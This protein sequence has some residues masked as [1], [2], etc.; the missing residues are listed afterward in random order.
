MFIYE[1][2]TKNVVSVKPDYSVSKAFQIL[3]ESRHSQLPVVD[4]N[5]KLTGLLTEKLLAEVNPSKAT[6]LSVYEINYLLSKTKVCDIMRTG[7]FKVNQNAL[8]EDA[9][10]IM[11]ENHIGSLPVVDDDNN[12]VGI[13]TRVDI[14]K[15]FIDI[16]GV[17]VPGT[18]LS[19]KASDKVGELAEISQIIA[20]HNVN[21]K[22]IS[23]F[24]TS[25]GSEIIIK[26][27]SFETDDIIN[28]LKQK[29]YEI[30]SV[31][32]QR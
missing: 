17:K 32:V 12:L 31:S 18:R 8:I 11:K 6:S 13:V 5:N 2:M 24:A 1:K 22:N 21:V 14:F 26:L 23:N 30:L 7:V 16:L 10:L 15:A 28:D 9:A 4:D 25:F 20:N 3:T 27:D 19:L 29:G